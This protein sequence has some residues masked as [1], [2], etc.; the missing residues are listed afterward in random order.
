MRPKTKEALENLFCAKWNLP[1]AANYCNL[2][3]K[4]CKIIFNEY[5]RLNPP[6]YVEEDT[7]N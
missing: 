7:K 6:R 1:Y 5:C 2:T 3:Q 4:E